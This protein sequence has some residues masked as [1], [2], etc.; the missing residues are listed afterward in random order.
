[1]PR[2]ETIR[3]IVAA[4]LVLFVA[5]PAAWAQ[6]YSASGQIGYLHEWEITGNLAKTVTR[7]GAEYSGTI[8]LRHV[9]LCSVNGVEQ[10]QARMQLKASSGRLEGTLIMDG[11]QCRIVASGS[12]GSGLLICGSGQDVPINLLIGKA[13][14]TEAADR[15]GL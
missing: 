2:A 14:E 12:S 7:L 5:A 11:D 4:I 1:M 8:T 9:G 3:V 10:K 15:A 13:V 6:T